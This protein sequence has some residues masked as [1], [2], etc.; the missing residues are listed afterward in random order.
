MF[1]KKLTILNRQ[2]IL[3]LIRGY[4]ILISPF[5]IKSCR[6]YPSCSNYTYEA[7]LKY[8]ALKGCYMGIK[9]ILK[10]NPFNKGGVDLP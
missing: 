1:L 10:C 2:I 8:G 6:F 3:K 7:V 5:L 4:Q 9:R